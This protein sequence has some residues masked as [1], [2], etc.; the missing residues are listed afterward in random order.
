MADS[1]YWA[2]SSDSARVLDQKRLVRLNASGREERRTVTHPGKG[3]PRKKPAAGRNGSLSTVFKE[4]GGSCRFDG[5][6]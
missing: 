3:T 5:W 4:E 6:G 1:L 2:V